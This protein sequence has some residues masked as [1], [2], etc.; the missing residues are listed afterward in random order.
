[1]G[2]EKTT[3]SMTLSET[4]ALRTGEDLPSLTR[5]RPDIG[6]SGPRVVKT[7]KRAGIGIR[8]VVDPSFRRSPDC[9]FAMKHLPVGGRRVKMSHRGTPQPSHRQFFHR[10]DAL[11][12]LRALPKLQM[13]LKI[14]INRA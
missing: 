14:W 2:S 12:P 6:Q 3:H 1:M 7:G 9:W 8:S 11:L 10:H 4:R 13:R 5:R